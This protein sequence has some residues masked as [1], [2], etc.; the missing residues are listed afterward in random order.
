MFL[1]TNIVKHEPLLYKL[2]E[3]KLKFSNTSKKTSK[4]ENQS[5]KD[6]KS[7]QQK[8]LFISKVDRGTT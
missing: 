3:R 8:K 5:K 2:A 4:L 1:K 6:Q 7:P